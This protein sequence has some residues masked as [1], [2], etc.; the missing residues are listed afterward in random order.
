MLAPVPL[1]VVEFNFD[2]F[3]AL[4][5]DIHRGFAEAMGRE[6]FVAEFTRGVREFYQPAEPWTDAASA[7]VYDWLMALPMTESREP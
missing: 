3:H 7:A 1:R 6:R 4:S 2:R 5:D